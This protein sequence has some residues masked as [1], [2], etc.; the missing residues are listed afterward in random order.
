MRLPLISMFAIVTMFFVTSTA[1]AIEFS[2]IGPD[3]FTVN[4]GD[5]F[6]VDIALDNASATSNVGVTGTITGLAGVADVVGGVAAQHFFVG[7]CTPTN[8]FAG[9]D[10]N[11]NPFYD[12]SDLSG[13][14]YG[15]PGS[16][17][18]V[19]ISALALNPTSA[20]GAI[21]PGL[22]GA[23]NEPSARDVTI[24][25][26]AVGAGVLTVGGT[27]GSGGNQPITNTASITVNVVPE[28]GTALL[29]GLGLVGLAA[30]GRR[31]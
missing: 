18:V 17:S 20:T 5:T 16:D 9:I 12:S 29:L 15:G 28:P 30:A 25:L 4:P 21:D 24:Q 1:S 23:L 13:N 22:D 2:I 27:F 14:G 6:T 10:T 3:T 31:K 19:I 8:C 26:Q 7:F 11:D